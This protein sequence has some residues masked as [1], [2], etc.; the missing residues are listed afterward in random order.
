MC[1]SYYL[2]FIIYYF[3][4]SFIDNKLNNSIDEEYFICEKKYISI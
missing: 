4:F 1:P 3:M 2:L